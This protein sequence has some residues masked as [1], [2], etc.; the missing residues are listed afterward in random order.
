VS[1]ACVSADRAP[2]LARTCQRWQTQSERS[3]QLHVGTKPKVISKLFEP[4]HNCL[5][6]DIMLVGRAK[7]AAE[8][9]SLRVQQP[10]SVL[11]VLS[12]GDLSEIATRPCDIVFG[13]GTAS[14][15][16]KVRQTRPG[17]QIASISMEFAGSGASA[18]S[19]VKKSENAN[20]ATL[21]FEMSAE[22]GGPST[23]V[24]TTELT[25]P[26]KI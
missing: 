10:S 2:C 17:R 4:V 5:A 8:S 3:I 25:T 12:E 7:S 24:I 20:G 14:V 22:E 23:I 19:S 6:N 9:T 16:A 1:R 11:V 15:L 26:E 21:T 18:M 13:R